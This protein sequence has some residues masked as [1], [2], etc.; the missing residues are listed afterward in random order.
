[1]HARSLEQ[2]LEM[3]ARTRPTPQSV[4]ALRAELQ[5]D[6]ALGGGERAQVLAAIESLAS[7]VT[8][9][10]EEP[11][12]STGRLEMLVDYRPGAQGGKGRLFLEVA[13]REQKTLG[14]PYDLDLPGIYLFGDEQGFS[15]LQV[16][17][18]NE[19][20]DRLDEVLAALRGLPLPPVDC[21]QARLTNGHVADV[22]DWVVF[23][24]IA[25]E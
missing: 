24:L 9:P 6:P 1:M 25:N 10:P 16:D 14:E 17:A 23:S 18:A 4:A 13:G 22:L 19:L 12:S 8:D 20:P 5:R 7:R 15:G 11:R 2:W 21:A 3:I